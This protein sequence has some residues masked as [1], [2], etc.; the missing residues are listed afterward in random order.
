MVMLYTKQ[1]RKKGKERVVQ[2]L[3][4]FSRLKNQDGTE[5]Q[6]HPSSSGMKCQ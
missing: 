5:S 2:N 6:V 4:L 1:N 3:E